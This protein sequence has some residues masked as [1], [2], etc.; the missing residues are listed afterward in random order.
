[1]REQPAGGWY[2]E[3]VIRLAAFS[4]SG[5]QT[6]PPHSPFTPPS[7]ASAFLQ[8]AAPKT[9]SSRVLSAD[10]P[11]RGETRRLGHAQLLGEVWEESRKLWLCPHPSASPRPPSPYPAVVV[12]QRAP[13]ESRNMALGA[14]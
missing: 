12:P 4:S 3:S 5:V 1:M 2:K 13:G 10:S 6:L 8:P 14:I 9:R 7:I 11:S